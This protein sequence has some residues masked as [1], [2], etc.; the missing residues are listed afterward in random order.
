[1]RVRPPPFLSALARSPVTGLTMTSSVFRRSSDSRLPRPAASTVR[2]TALMPSE[3][4]FFS[5]AADLGFSL[6]RYSWKKKGCLGAW[7]TISSIG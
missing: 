2:K 3:A 6:L 1:M 5:A 4:A 7:E